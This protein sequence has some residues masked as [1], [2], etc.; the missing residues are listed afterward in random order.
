LLFLLITYF[1]YHK[2]TPVY[3][4]LATSVLMLFLTFYFLKKTLNKKKSELSQDNTQTLRIKQ[5]LNTSFPML[6]T[7]AMGLVLT[8]TDIIMLGMFTTVEA[9]GG[10]AV[11]V[12]LASLTT[13]V[14][15]SINVVIAPRFS[16]T[17][18]SN[19]MQALKS[20]VQ[21]SAK[22]IFYSTLPIVLVLFIFGKFALGLFGDEFVLGYFAMCIL[23][24]GR[25]INIVSGSVGYLM[26]MTGYQ[27]EYNYIMII[28]AVINIVLN[29][30]LIPIYGI[31]GAAMASAISMVLWNIASVVFVKIKMKIYAG[32][33]PF[34]NIDIR[35]LNA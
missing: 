22:L 18:H 25:L 5:I 33:I 13:F 15:S 31:E 3:A 16:E 29:Y 1:F 35:K 32:Y 2:N 9:V 4:V 11:V 30:F 7:S 14:L 34:K 10:Y 28:S 8:Q 12:K 26:N 17:Y 21:K 27:K 19:D 20:T 6:L 24:V 23:L